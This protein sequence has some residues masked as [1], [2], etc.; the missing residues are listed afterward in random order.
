MLRV[1]PAEEAAP[2][3]AVTVTFDRPVAG[4]ARS[5][6][7]SPG[8]LPHRPRRSRATVD[9]R[10]PVTLRFRPAAPL[11]ADRSLHRHRRRP[12]PGH[13]RQPAG[14]AVR[15]SLSGA[16]AARAGRV[17]GGPRSG[18]RVSHARRP[19]RSGRSTRRSIRRS[20]R[21]RCTSSSTGSAARRAWSGWRSKSSAPS[22][23]RTA[24]TSA[25]PAGGTATAR[26]IRFAGWS[27]SPRGR[28]CR[29]AA[30]AHLVVPAAF[31][32]PGPR[33]AAA[34]GARHLRRLPPGRGADCG[35]GGDGLPHRPGRRCAS[36]RRC[37]APT[38][39]GTSRCG[40]AVP[41]AL[42][43][44]ADVRA[45]WVLEAR[46]RPRTGYAVVADRA[47][48][49]GFGQRLTGNPVVTMRHH[50]LRP[51]DQLSLRPR[52]G[53][54]E[55]R[56]H[57]RAH[58]RQRGHARGAD[59]RR[60]PTRS[61]RRSSPGANGAGA[62]S[63]PRCCRRRRAAADRGARA[64]ATGCGCTAC[65]CPPPPRPAARHADADGGAGDQPPARQRRA[66]AT[67]RSRWCR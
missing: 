20:W 14:G 52:A 13:G 49:D 56:A 37:A 36:A 12:L 28:R 34:M 60:S 22:P 59:R 31:D 3:S 6:R 65:S 53:R 5:D 58:L 30:P 46:A 1:V 42:G 35:W 62:S 29:A 24:G 26:P 48:T 17:A 38:C 51:G 63:G 61:R 54:A 40:P 39:C 55:G 7:G 23:R 10:D 57:L 47:L 18:A 27:V 64:R 19:V 16:G 43:D 33:R 67:A 25:R 45:E 32:E 9:W 50:G 15:P 21:A 2:T 41:F 4:L 8:A 66:A 44:T 11:P